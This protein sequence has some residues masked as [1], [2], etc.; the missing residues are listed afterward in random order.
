MAATAPPGGN[1]GPKR[2]REAHRVR[3]DEPGLP[4]VIVPD[5]RHAGD[6]DSLA[7]RSLGVLASPR[8]AVGLTAERDSLRKKAEAVIA[9]L[10]ALEGRLE[11]AEIEQ[12]ALKEEPRRAG[13]RSEG[14]REELKRERSRA[15]L[16]EVAGRPVSGGVGLGPGSPPPAT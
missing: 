7:G 12:L 5:V 16:E 11:A 6:G 15:G 9:G 1:P 4:H 14:L 8:R 13:E 2:G 3:L 10:D